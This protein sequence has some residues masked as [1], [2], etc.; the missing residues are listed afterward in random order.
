[1]SGD[2][3]DSELQ[4]FLAIEQQKAQFQA[5]IHHLTDLC[6]DLC[7]DKPRDKLDGKT[8]ACVTNCAD[9]FVD[10]SLAIAGRFQQMVQRSM[11]G[12]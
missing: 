3:G 2:K 6:W 7:V 9:R 10:V 12:Q 1:M 5:H 8:E 11:Q 4:E